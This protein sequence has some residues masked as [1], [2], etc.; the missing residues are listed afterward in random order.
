MHKFTFAAMV[1]VL[2]LFTI[3]CSGNGGS[4]ITPNAGSGITSGVESYGTNNPSV[5]WGYYDL[6]FDFENQTVEAVPNRNVMFTANVVQFV[7]NPAANL[8]F[9]IHGT[10]VDPGDAWV[11]VDIDVGITHPFPSFHQYDGWDVRGIFM[12]AGSGTMDYNA[13][14]KY[15]VYGTDQEMY[16]YDLGDDPEIGYTDPYDGL[17]GMPDGYTRWWNAAEFTDPGPL[18]YTEGAL[19]TPGYASSLTATLNPY[20]YFCDDLGVEDDLWTWLNDGTNADNHGIFTAGA[21]NTRNY[22]LRFPTPDP[23]VSYGYAIAAT[24]GE[25]PGEPPPAC[26][27]NAVEAIA[28]T[29]DV[30]DNIYYVDAGNNGGNFIADIHVWSWDH[31]S[32]VETEYIQPSTIFIESDVIGG[33]VDI[34]GAGTVGGT[35]YSTYSCDIPTTTVTS[36][37]DSEFWVICEYSD[38]DYTCKY[39]GAAPTDVLAAFFRFDL[40]ISDT[41]PNFPPDAEIL[42]PDPAYAT[43]NRGYPV[44]GSGSSDPD[45]DPLIYAWDLNDDGVFGDA[46]DDAWTVEG[47]SS[48]V[49]VNVLFQ[50]SGTLDFHLRVDDEKGGQNIDDATAEV[51]LHYGG[52]DRYGFTL[53][54]QPESGYD[55]A[56]PAAGIDVQDDLCV[57]NLS[58]GTAVQIY[59]ATGAF[60]PPEG[61]IASRYTNNYNTFTDVIQEITFSDTTSNRPWCFVDGLNNN[62]TASFMAGAWTADQPW[63]LLDPDY[64]DNPLYSSVAAY[65]D[66]CGTGNGYNTNW[67]ADWAHDGLPDPWYVCCDATNSFTTGNHMYILF[68]YDNTG[69]AGA[70]PGSPDGDYVVRRIAPPY[71]STAGPNTFRNRPTNIGTGTG[72]VDDSDHEHIRLAVDCDPQETD[73]TYSELMFIL[74]S[75]DDVEITDVNFW[76][77]SPS[78]GDQAVSY[79]TIPSGSFAGTPLDIEMISMSASGEIQNR[80][81]VL[82]DDGIGGWF[83]EVWDINISTGSTLLYT[84][85]PGTDTAYR[86]DIDGATGD[87]HVFHDDGTGNIAVTVFQW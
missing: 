5:L 19:A 43:V 61:Y 22:Y 35:N 59:R 75:E 52:H 41:N 69:W 62:G 39:P 24:W 11:D 18:G 87:A 8:S 65:C 14:L 13:A 63:I 12:G 2:F 51:Y 83:L 57:M 21:T 67:V 68:V 66:G 34:G 81:V 47:D 64:L 1:V 17:V 16:D 15:P 72:L 37:D 49:A 54:T 74:D 6:Y 53:P 77:P 33:A 55:D 80:L 7:N 4:P 32:T 26:V 71:D 82:E 84:S 36:S 10:P 79:G 9:I 46:T 48:L 70:N 78:I 20:K 60:Y 27:E 86:M 45:G 31:D 38:Y 3:S 85:A 30:T 73:L 76:H 42:Q 58:G 25:A 28:L 23:N 44:D 56:W 29:V 40:P 50:V